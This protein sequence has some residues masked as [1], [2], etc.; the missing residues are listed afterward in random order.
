MVV[1]D[2]TSRSSGTRWMAKKQQM[3]WNRVAVKPFLDVRSAVLDGA[4]E[5]LP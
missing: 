5:S 2:T 4:L 3:R 1:K